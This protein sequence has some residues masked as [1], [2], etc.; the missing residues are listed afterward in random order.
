MGSG[1]LPSAAAATGSAWSRV[2]SLGVVTAGVVACVV[3]VTAGA[4]VVRWFDIDCSD[5]T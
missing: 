3:V 4:G 5:Q 2:G 1:G